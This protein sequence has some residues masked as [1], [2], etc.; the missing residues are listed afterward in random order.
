M[1]LPFISFR[2]LVKVM[3]FIIFWDGFEGDRVLS[4]ESGWRGMLVFLVFGVFVVLLQ[5]KGL[6]VIVFGLLLHAS[7]SSERGINKGSWLIY[8]LWLYT[9]LTYRFCLYIQLGLYLNL[10][11]SFPFGMVVYGEVLEWY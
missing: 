2:H 1:S 3:S 5:V 10:C 7:F 11:G 9:G 4:L 8:C 6:L